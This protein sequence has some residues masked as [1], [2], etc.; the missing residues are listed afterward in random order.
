MD[1]LPA[2]T[3][4]IKVESLGD[5]EARILSYKS[6]N[7]SAQFIYDPDPKRRTI[8]IQDIASKIRWY[9]TLTTLHD[10]RHTASSKLCSAFQSPD[11]QEGLESYFNLHG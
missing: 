2:P 1:D 6:E 10:T 7:P 8:G 9:I 3:S 4:N 11:F 5:L